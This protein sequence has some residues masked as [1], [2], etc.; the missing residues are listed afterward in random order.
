MSSYIQNV[1]ILL[2]GFLPLF[3]YIFYALRRKHDNW[4]IVI[5]FPFAL[6]VS[7]FFPLWGFV[8]WF[9][10]ITATA[11]E[12]VIVLL[13]F[14][15]ILCLSLLA[16]T[17]GILNKRFRRKLVARRLLT[18]A[19]IF[20]V[21]ITFFPLLNA[22]K[23][24]VQAKWLEQN[25]TIIKNQLPFENEPNSSYIRLITKTIAESIAY[26]H[27]SQFGSNVRIADSNIILVN[28]TLYWAMMFTYQTQIPEKYNKII[29]V[30]LVDVN[31]PNADPIVMKTPNF[32]YGDGL[33]YKHKLNNQQFWRYP[34]DTWT[35]AHSRNYPAWTGENWVYI[36]LRTAKKA[37]WGLWYSDGIDIINVTTAEVIKHYA[38]EEF[39]SLPKYVSQVYSEWFLEM[40]LNSWGNKRDT[41]S[42]NNVSMFAGWNFL[43]QPSLDRFEMSEDTRYIVNPDDNNEVISIITTNPKTLPNTL[44]GIFITNRT[45]LYYYDLHESGYISAITAEQIAQGLQI[46]PSGG[47]YDA[48]MPL[49]YVVNTAVGKRLVWY[50]PVYWNSYDENIYRL[51][52]F[53]II[54]A[55]DT[56]KIVSVMAGDYTGAELVDEAL[57]QFKA[58]FTGT[59]QDE[60]IYAQIQFINSYTEDGD[61]IFVMHM[62]N[63]STSYDEIVRI[64]HDDLSE[65]QWNEVL[66]SQVG[67]IVRF[68]TYTSEGVFWVS[69]YEKLS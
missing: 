5:G 55:K 66:I 20:F 41:T 14:T 43:R 16:K 51:A 29:G 61:T 19:T 25:V 56:T 13:I 69:F 57:K 62:V 30:I 11:W 46:A 8:F 59:A 63:A 42:P 48:G 58:L 45:G 21:S 4:F 49:P 47:A 2:L 40:T 1:F 28:N 44:H 10:I 35:A 54:D 6:A 31:N 38:P 33:F 27:S 68:K 32:L 15:S 9:K 67:D 64:K 37:P 17:H 23:E 22:H 24:V 26:Q 7:M 3:A 39:S 50:V 52:Y 12:M 34:Q 36:S 18:Y 65:T 60:Y 53:S